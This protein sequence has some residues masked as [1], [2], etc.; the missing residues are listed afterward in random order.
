LQQL[1]LR[2]AALLSNICHRQPHCGNNHGGGD[3]LQDSPQT[4]LKQ[5]NLCGITTKSLPLLLSLLLAQLLL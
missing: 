1:T 4:R 2:T 5:Q 3:F